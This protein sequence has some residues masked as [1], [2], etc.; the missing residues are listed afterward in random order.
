M[1]GGVVGGGHHGGGGVLW[2]ANQVPTYLGSW[3]C[4]LKLSIS[5]FLPILFSTSLRLYGTFTLGLSRL[6]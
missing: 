3:R 6:P 1:V 4:Y 2:T 5:V